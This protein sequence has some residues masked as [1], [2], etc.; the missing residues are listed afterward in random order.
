MRADNA[1]ERQENKNKGERA[2]KKNEKFWSKSH[3]FLFCYTGTLLLVHSD[4]RTHSTLG[5]TSS[6]KLKSYVVRTVQVLV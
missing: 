2:E 1:C 6:C 3:S 4:T 5:S